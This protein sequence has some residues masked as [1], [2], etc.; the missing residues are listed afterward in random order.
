MVGVP[1][2]E[3]TASMAKSLGI[4]LTTLAKVGRLDVTI[5]GLDIRAAAGSPSTDGIDVDSSRN[6]TIIPE[7]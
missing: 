4:G 7:D 3:K 5:D 2:S 1:S 6:V